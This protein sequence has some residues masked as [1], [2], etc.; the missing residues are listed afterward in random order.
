MRTFVVSARFNQMFKL[1]TQNYLLYDGD[2]GVCTKLAERA[3][4]MDRK[5]RFLIEPYQ[6]FSDQDLSQAGLNQS[7]CARKLQLIASTGAVY[8]GAFAVNQFLWT[9]GLRS[10]ALMYAIPPFLLAEVLGYAVFARHRHRISR[11]MGLNECSVA[12]RNSSAKS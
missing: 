1:G 2:C 4:K 12:H 9:C 7:M 11:W 8:G 3:K 5:R 10:V 6:N